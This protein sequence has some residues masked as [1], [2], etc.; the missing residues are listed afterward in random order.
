[1]GLDPPAIARTESAR[2][3]RQAY[4]QHRAQK[5]VTR[6]V[7]VYPG[8]FSP[9]V[10]AEP[11][12]CGAPE[13]HHSTD[14]HSSFP[15]PAQCPVGHSALSLWST[16]IL[17]A[18]VLA[19][20]PAIS[21]FIIF[22]GPFCWVLDPREPLLGSRNDIK[23]G[24][25]GCYGHLGWVAPGDRRW[26]V[27]RGWEAWP[28]S[29]FSSAVNRL[30]TKQHRLGWGWQGAEA[31]QRVPWPLPGGVGVGSHVECI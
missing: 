12:P 23:R 11:C 26:T 17:P 30:H 4:L 14:V 5:R 9:A 21:R 20:D 3:W 28:S 7:V 27:V 1:M 31:S 2:M 19:S 25:R 13:L 6:C 24:G 15:S 10:W 16:H 22:S 18:Y 29:E 8:A